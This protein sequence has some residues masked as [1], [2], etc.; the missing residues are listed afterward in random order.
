MVNSLCRK[1]QCPKRSSV[2]LK[3][4]TLDQKRV[5]TGAKDQKEKKVKK[6]NHSTEDAL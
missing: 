3:V 6:K 5:M 4:Y 2:C 1:Q